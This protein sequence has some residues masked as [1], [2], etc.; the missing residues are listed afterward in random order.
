MPTPLDNPY[1][2]SSQQDQHAF[3]GLM[4]LATSDDAFLW[5]GRPYSIWVTIK[6][7][8]NNGQSLLSTF[9]LFYLNA[10]FFIFLIRGLTAAIVIGV[11]LLIFS[12]IAAIEYRRRQTFYGITAKEIWV[13]RPNAQLV[14]YPISQ[15]TR[16]TAQE[17]SLSYST[18]Q[19][20]V[21]EKTFLFQNIHAPE[22]LHQII[23]QLQPKNS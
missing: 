19:G 14:Q 12:S 16:L 23:S 15:L 22:K 9:I 21:Y 5:T 13:K 18:I 10:I 7:Q 3:N 11:F 8:L 1:H 6:K 2:H 17:T 4:K 20:S